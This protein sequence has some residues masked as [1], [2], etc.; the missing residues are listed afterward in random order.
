MY[1]RIFLRN[2]ENIARINVISRDLYVDARTN[3]SV[4]PNYVFRHNFSIN[5]VHAYLEVEHSAVIL[6]QAIE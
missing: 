1:P 2:L 4:R 3:V 5:Q 6:L